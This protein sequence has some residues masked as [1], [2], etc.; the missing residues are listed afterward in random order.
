MADKEKLTPEQKEYFDKM[1]IR[2]IG[3]VWLGDEL[4]EIYEHGGYGTIPIGRRDPTKNKN[5]DGTG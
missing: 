5:K 2:V 3:T 4:F 1:A